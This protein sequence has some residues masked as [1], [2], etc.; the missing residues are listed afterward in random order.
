MRFQTI[1]ILTELEKNTWKIFDTDLD[2]DN[3][4]TLAEISRT[5]QNGEKYNSE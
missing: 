1:S 4:L 5:E 2:S 3:N